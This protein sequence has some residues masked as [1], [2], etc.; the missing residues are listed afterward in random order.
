[1][2]RLR[3]VFERISPIFLSK[4]VSGDISMTVRERPAA[5]RRRR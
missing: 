4:A 3:H 2:A 1:M 5:G